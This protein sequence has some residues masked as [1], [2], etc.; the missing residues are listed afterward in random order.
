MTNTTA[1]T[2]ILSALPLFLLP[3]NAQAQEVTEVTTDIQP[4]ATLPNNTQVNQNGNT[5][6]ITGGTNSGNNLF[7][8]F[9]SFSVGNG[10]TASF[11]SI[12]S[13]IQDIFSRVTG[14]SISDINGTI[15][16]LN[17]NA[18]LYLVNPN[19][20]VFHENASLNL[21]GSFFATTADGLKFNEDF[22]F[23]ADDGNAPPPILEVNM[24]VGANFR[25][26][27]GNIT[28]L[29]GNALQNPPTNRFG[30]TVSSG[31]NITLLG[32]NVTFDGGQIAAP[33]GINVEIGGLIAEGMVTIEQDGSLSFPP[34][35]TRGDITFTNRSIVAGIPFNSPE[36][37]SGS[38]N[39]NG[40]NI[41]VQNQSF[42]IAGATGVSEESDVSK[43]GD[44]T[45]NAQGGS[46]E[47]LKS[48]IISESESNSTNDFA[49]IELAAPQ[50]SISIINSVISAANTSDEGFAG[51]IILNANNEINILNSSIGSRNTA[52]SD[53]NPDS[54]NRG[55][56]NKGRIFIGSH[57]NKEVEVTPPSKVII[58]G[59]RDPE[60]EDDGDTRSKFVFS[61]DLSTTNFKRPNG[62]AG[63]IEIKASEEID[64]SGSRVDSN[65]TIAKG[66][67]NNNPNNSFGEV[68]LKVPQGN[69]KGTIILNQAEINNT[70]SNT[71]FAGDIILNAPNSI[72]ITSSQLLADG[73]RGRIV[74]GGEVI[75]ERESE[76]LIEKTRTFSPQNVTITD[77][78]SLST[79]N[80]YV[81]NPDLK[82]T[83]VNGGDITIDANQN[84]SISNGSTISAVTA[85]K[86]DAGDVILNA[87]NNITIRD[88]LVRII[89]VPKNSD[90]EVLDIEQF[91]R[92]DSS[93]VFS[94]VVA[95]GDGKA[96]DITIQSNSLTLSN[97]ATIQTQIDPPATYDNFI[98]NGEPISDELSQE[99]NRRFYRDENDLP[100][101]DGLPAGDGIPG[102]INIDVRDAITLSGFS[103]QKI[104]G[105][106]RPIPIKNL[107][108]SQV[109][110]E[111]IGDGGIVNIQ[112]NSLLIDD[113]SVISTANLSRGA[114]G[115]L[116]INARIIEQNEG[117]ISASSNSGTSGNIKIFTNTLSLDKNSFITGTTQSGVAGSVIIE[118]QN[119]TPL[120][121]L[122]LNNSNITVEAEKGLGGTAGNIFITTND[123]FQNGGKISANTQTS[124]ANIN[125]SIDN[126]WILRNISS[127]S[128]NADG[129]GNITEE[130]SKGG[131]LNINRNLNN[132]E[133]NI[134]ENSELLI[135]A[136]PSLPDGSDITANAEGNAD[137]GQINLKAAGVF[138][139]RERATLSAF[140][141]FNVSSEFGEDGIIE[142]DTFDDP[143][144]SLLELPASVGDASDTISQNPCE[145][146][147]GSEFLVTGK[148]GF[149]ANPQNNFSSNDVRVGLVE[150]V[151]AG[152]QTATVEESTISTEE[153]EVV[154]AQGWVFNNEGKVILTAHDPTQ[155]GVQRNK[156]HLTGCPIP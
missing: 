52:F 60:P 40:K 105:N 101:E 106:D 89:D 6:E 18:N 97:G 121:I 119:D 100:A 152:N 1:K 81:T 14:S 65:T 107:I 12:N 146:G 44:I 41:N 142:I 98:L 37:G 50:D 56:G 134:N 34:E 108:S 76:A 129:R 74:I 122:S 93:G 17:S 23:S 147:V 94:N 10:D 123:L 35:T 79:T 85:R 130:N 84:I 20:I 11:Q 143:S 28:N 45:L 43:A 55:N 61:T 46:I 47:L 95:G 126:D 77:L 33:N 62:E 24:P 87:G 64:I 5:V 155:Q 99:L 69:P 72:N 154:P 153:P 30:L 26:D 15:Q 132:V 31:K 29:A 83:P 49:E 63:R 120:E 144:S 96:G 27:P 141:D 2:L 148:G 13:N 68:I 133:D 86:G 32:G 53:L 42:L 8:S 139:I 115:D 111:A 140:N 58:R 116:K 51:D 102:N 25:D 135:F 150:P 66:D 114:G 112:S 7:H 48:A 73:E 57:P 38:I 22:T 118:N 71:G 88:G 78:S 128:A 36:Q 16:V 125:L 67:D 117:T 127:V 91:E 104:N 75:E 90:Q 103:T 9:N 109:G 92:F 145:Q 59:K 110:T 19:G 131:N 39:I 149:P 3:L 113:F 82:D 54:L 137:G 4:D 136:F 70:N 124:G 21:N 151:P 80:S 138:G 156:D